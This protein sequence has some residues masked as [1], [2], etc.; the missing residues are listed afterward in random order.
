MMSYLIWIVLLEG[1]RQFAT[2][3][4]NAI[5]NRATPQASVTT[6]DAVHVV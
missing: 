2:V 6:A 1:H 3:T 4:R 5:R